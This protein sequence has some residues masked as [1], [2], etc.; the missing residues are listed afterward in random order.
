[1]KDYKVIYKILKTLDRYA[2]NEGFDYELISAKHMKIAYEK[3]EQLII[4]LQKDGFLDGIA[5]TQT[6][7]DKFPHITGS[8]KPYITLKGIDFIE[9]N[10]AMQK[11]KEDLKLIGEFF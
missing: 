4:L 1:M 9:N 3:W 7:S 10:S 8:I 6:L 11:I 5:Y 2:G